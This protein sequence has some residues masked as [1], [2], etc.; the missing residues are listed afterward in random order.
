MRKAYATVDCCRGSSCL[1]FFVRRLHGPSKVVGCWAEGVCQL[2]P[3]GNV[4]AS[5][6]EVAEGGEQ[7]VSE[8]QLFGTL[9]ACLSASFRTGERARVPAGARASGSNVLGGGLCLRKQRGSTFWA[10]RIVTHCPMN[11]GEKV[12]YDPS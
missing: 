11:V 3:F 4:S 12:S 9:Q 5:A 6:R 8:G 10:T 7:G 2:T 1:E